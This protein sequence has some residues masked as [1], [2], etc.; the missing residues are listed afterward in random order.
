MAILSYDTEKYSEETIQ[1]IVL[2]YK[3][4]INKIILNPLIQIDD[5]DIMLDLEKQKTIDIDFNF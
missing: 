1:L 2:K 5:L 3:K 4:L